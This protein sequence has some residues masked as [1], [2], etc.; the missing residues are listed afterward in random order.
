MAAVNMKLQASFT[1]DT[2]VDGAAV[3]VTKTIAVNLLP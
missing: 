2:P 3:A 1:Y